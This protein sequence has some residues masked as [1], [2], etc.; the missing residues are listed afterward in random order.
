MGAFYLI[1]GNE[2]FSIKERA[3]AF[4]RSLCGDDPESNSALEIIRG[5][6]E[7]EKAGAVLEKVLDSIETPSFLSPEKIVW[8]K[9]F[10]KFD[11]AS[12][13]ASTKKKLSKLDQLSEVLKAGIPSDVTLILD[14]P[15]DRRKAF[16]KLCDKVCASS[17][18]KLE[19]F[20]K[21][22][23]KSKGYLPGLIMKIKELA[24]ENGE[25][26]M[27]DDAANFL[28]ET[29]GGDAPR[30]KNEVDKLISYVGDARVITL[31]DCFQI[32]SK[33]SETLAWAFSSALAERNP[34]KAL[35]LIPGIIET[36]GQ[37]RGG[38]AKPE[39]AIIAAVHSEFQRLLAIKCEGKKFNIPD[40]AGSN[41][42]YS[43]AENEKEKHPESPLLAMHPF[44][45]FKTW[46]NAARFSD[47]DFARA[48][49]AILKA[50]KG[51]V[52]GSDARRE[53]ETLVLHIAGGDLA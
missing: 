7:G 41:F 49:E 33:G 38:S 28:A 30:L 29:I 53:L 25:K 6:T 48:F 26:R 47:M 24:L 35:D 22:D 20:E 8:L 3:N 11:E 9:H 15:M 27:N 14:G 46:E 4:I 16:F 40:S 13:E 10:N 37:E 52:T 18:G 36:M 44:R 34:R 12:A 39:I 50:S 32:C 45:A 1:S 43:L 42:F 31:E 5:D 21:T 51:M 23:T 19:W 2:D 17:G